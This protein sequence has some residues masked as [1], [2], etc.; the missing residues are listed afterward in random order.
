MV[1]WEEQVYHNMALETN[2]LKTPVKSFIVDA[3][4]NW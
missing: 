2:G 4:A 1:L 3:G